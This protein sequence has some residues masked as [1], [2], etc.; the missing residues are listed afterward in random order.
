[1]K[2]YRELIVWKKSIDLVVEIYKLT[3]LFPRKEQYGLTSQIRRSAVSIPSNIAEGFY[4]GH[5]REYV[6]FLRI[7]Y[8][9]GGELETQLVLA[10][11]LHFLVHEKYQALENS[12]SE[13]MKM[14]N[15]L[16]YVLTVRE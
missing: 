5:Q 14:L 16:I 15:K 1:M 8:A 3:E 10:E 13:I 12:L 6:R 9:S 7:A 2:S 11:A 4:R